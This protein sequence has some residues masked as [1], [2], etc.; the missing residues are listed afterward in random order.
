LRRLRGRERAQPHRGGAAPRRPSTLPRAEARRRHR[1]QLPAARARRD[2]LPPA[3]DP[4]LR[5]QRPGDRP[6]GARRLRARGRQAQG[7]RQVRRVAGRG[8]LFDAS[9]RA[10]GR[11]DLIELGDVH[12]DERLEVLGPLDAEDLGSGLPEDGDD[13][14]SLTT[15]GRVAAAGQADGVSDGKWTP[16]RAI[17]LLHTDR[18]SAS[19]GSAEVWGLDR[20]KWCACVLIACVV[21]GTAAAA[22]ASPAFRTRLFTFVDRSRTITVA[23]RRVPRTLETLVRYPA[24]GGP[25][26]L[27]VF[28]HGFALAPATYSRLLSAWARAGYVVAAPAFPLEKADAPGGPNESDLVNEPTDV[29]FVISRLLNLDSRR[30]GVLGGKIDPARIA[31]AGHSDGAVA[32]L[33]VAYDRRFRDPRVRAAIVLSGAELSGMG[34]FPVAGPPLFAAQGTADPINAP[35]TTAAFF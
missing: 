19:V 34:S 13:R 25:L 35:A 9:G 21:A 28:A 8:A 15:A 10:A 22:P 24:S 30:G 23:G 2:R 18:C 20:L 17:E 5:V 31:V 26:P 3:R 29:S 14:A 11:L 33:A 6:C 27:I 7:L 1:T 12:R 32:A 16:P 4:D